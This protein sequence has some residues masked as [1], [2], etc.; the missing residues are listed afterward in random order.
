VLILRSKDGRAGAT[1]SVMADGGVG[2]TLKGRDGEKAMLAVDPE[3]GP[4]LDLGD[5]RRPKGGRPGEPKP[6][7]E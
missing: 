2:L 1:L 3:A 5:D 6:G 4:I 7:A